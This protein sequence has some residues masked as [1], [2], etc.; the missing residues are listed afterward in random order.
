[1]EK[2]R[3]KI[4]NGGHMEYTLVDGEYVATSV[5]TAGGREWR[6][7][8]CAHRLSQEEMDIVVAANAGRII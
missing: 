2:I 1:M 7:V 4:D 8:E 6:R 3:V 5:S